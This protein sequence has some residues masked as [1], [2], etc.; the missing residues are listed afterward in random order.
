MRERLRE[1][2]RQEENVCVGERERNEK[3]CVRA[4]VWQREEENVRLC[5]REGEEE[6]VCLCV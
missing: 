4:R 5:E 3:K 2:D 6:N 1:Q